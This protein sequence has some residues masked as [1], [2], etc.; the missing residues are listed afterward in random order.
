MMF[1]KSVVTPR[2]TEGNIPM[3]GSCSTDFSSQV[4]KD[5][6]SNEEEEASEV[7][8]SN[9]EPTEDETQ[10]TTSSRKGPRRD[11]SLL[12]E[13]NTRKSPIVVPKRQERKKKRKQHRIRVIAIRSSKSC[14]NGTGQRE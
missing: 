13:I 14:Y 9:S 1:S 12:P 10:P 5:N 6:E 3:N 7:R 2:S 8:I 4:E 11:N